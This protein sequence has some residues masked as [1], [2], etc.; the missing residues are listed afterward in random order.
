MEGSGGK[1]KSLGHG[2]KRHMLVAL[3]RAGLAAAEHEVVE[4]GDKT[5]DIVQIRITIAGRRAI[6]R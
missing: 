5:I 2:F 4:A 3:V 6:E 1:L